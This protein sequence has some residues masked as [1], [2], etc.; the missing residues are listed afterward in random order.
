MELKTKFGTITVDEEQIIHFPRGI[1]GFADYHRYV[2]VEREDSIFSFLQ[3]V[4]EPGLTFV[5]IMPELVRADYEVELSNEEI[6]LLQISSP[7]DG[8]V[9]G[10]VTIPENVAEMTVN[11]QAPVVI[12][13]KER[14]G[15]QLIIAGDTFHTKHNVIAEMHKN[16]YL[17]QQKS[18]AAQRTEDIS[19][20]V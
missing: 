19:E 7:E 18:G 11:L 17:I 10:I 2:L 8:K 5:V 15:A 16:A 1:L 3:S 4:D 12:N 6:D 9:Y 20:S 13:T 14:L